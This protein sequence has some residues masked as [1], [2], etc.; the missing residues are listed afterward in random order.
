MYLEKLYGRIEINADM[1]DTTMKDSNESQESVTNESKENK[2][3][4]EDQL[5]IIVKEKLV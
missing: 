2:H 3:S 1:E 5:D 4:Y